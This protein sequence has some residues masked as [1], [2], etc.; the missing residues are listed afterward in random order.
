MNK[1]FVE[2]F[3]NQIE[4]LMRASDKKEYVQDEAGMYL[5]VP[6][7]EHLISE[8]R[9]LIKYGESKIALENMLENLN[10][11]SILLDESVVDLARQ[12]FEVQVT[13]D[14]ERLLNKLVMH[15]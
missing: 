14:M 12:A 9:E 1:E 15:K 10:E 5:K 7:L 8:A 2:M 13:T 6:Y 3:I 11:V 4:D